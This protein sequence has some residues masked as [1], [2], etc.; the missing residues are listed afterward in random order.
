MDEGSDRVKFLPRCEE[1][2]LDLLK[3]TGQIVN[4]LLEVG[5]VGY[6]ANGDTQ[7]AIV[8][9]LVQSIDG[10]SLDEEIIGTDTWS[11]LVQRETRTFIRSEL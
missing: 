3:L 5:D 11:M 4:E 1:G 6:E 2:G 10:F 9:F 7:V 8:I